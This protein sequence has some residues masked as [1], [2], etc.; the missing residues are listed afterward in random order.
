MCS[1]C[2]MCAVYMWWYVCDMYVWVASC[3]LIQTLYMMCGVCYMCVCAVYMWWCV[4][5]MYMYDASCTLANTDTDHVFSSAWLSLGSAP[6]PLCCSVG[7]LLTVV[8]L[9]PVCSQTSIFRTS[10]CLTQHYCR[11]QCAASGFWETFINL[12]LRGSI[13]FTAC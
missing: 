3:I 2:C 13:Y 9:E 11:F 1:V 10:S 6:W 8:S 4:C 5:G 12:L 7:I